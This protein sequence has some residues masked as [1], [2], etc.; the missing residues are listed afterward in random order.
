MQK[1][2]IIGFGVVGKAA[3]KTLSKKYKI[4]KYD[5]YQ[6]LDSFESLLLC[7]FI[8]IMVPTPFDCEKNRVDDSAITDTLKILEER[9]YVHTVI[10]KSTVPP[11]SCDRYSN[12]YNLN[13][14]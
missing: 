8:F 4:I 5:K 2:G 14:G 3:S 12:D 9:D 10:I 7:D 6:D 13:M 11:G 1:V